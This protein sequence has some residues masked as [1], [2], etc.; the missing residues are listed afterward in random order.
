MYLVDTS[1]VSELRRV[2][3][4]HGSPQ[5]AA[6]QAR[7]RPGDCYLSVVTLMELEIGVLRAERRDAIQGRL[8]RQWL[9]EA[10]RPAF[11]QRL[12]DIDRRVAERA[13]HLHVPDPRPANDA[14]IA[15]TALIHE[16][17]V[18][19]GN[20]RDFAGTGVLILNPWEST[21]I[22]EAPAQYGT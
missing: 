2:A 19:T 18:V 7:C 3:A 5:V 22:Q 13:A 8:L 12:L 20:T 21:S 6:W 11:A 16:L 17:V 4:G 9:D 14:L 15:A 10:L 1:V